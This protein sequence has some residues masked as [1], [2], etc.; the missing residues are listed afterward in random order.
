MIHNQHPLHHCSI[1]LADVCHIFGESDAPEHLP[2]VK[3]IHHIRT[4]PQRGM[5]PAHSLHSV[6]TAEAR[7]AAEDDSSDGDASEAERWA[8]RRA[9]SLERADELRASSHLAHRA[10]CDPT[11]LRR[12]HPQQA[13]AVS[14]TCGGVW[15]PAPVRGGSVASEAALRRKAAADRERLQQLRPEHAGISGVRCLALPS[16]LVC[17][18]MT[19]RDP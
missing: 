8:R 11:P 2:S 4:V 9:A 13:A 15:G 17:D 6:H 12:W 18:T 10:T 1:S 19:W 5:P 16:C 14:P 7:C 3:S